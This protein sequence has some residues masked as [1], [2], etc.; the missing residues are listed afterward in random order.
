LL[1]PL[2]NERTVYSQVDMP[3]HSD[4]L[5]HFRVNLPLFVHLDATCVEE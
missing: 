4:T 2:F 5:S 1:L 3:P